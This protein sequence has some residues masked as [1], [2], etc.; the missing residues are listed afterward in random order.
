MTRRRYNGPGQ[1]SA[2]NPNAVVNSDTWVGKALKVSAEVASGAWDGPITRSGVRT[3]DGQT[4]YTGMRVLLTQQA[5]YGNYAAHAQNG[6]WVANDDGPWSRPEDYDESKDVARAMVVAVSGGDLEHDTLY[7][8]KGNTSITPGVSVTSWRKISSDTTRRFVVSNDPLIPGHYD[9][10]DDALF[11]ISWSFG[12]SYGG[13]IVLVGEHEW[14][15]T[16]YSGITIEGWVDEPYGGTGASIEGTITLQTGTKLKSLTIRGKIV[17]TAGWH[18]Y[19]LEKLYVD[20]SWASVAGPCFKT[21]TTE[22]TQ[23]AI[24]DC[25]FV[26]WDANPTIEL[27]ETTYGFIENCRVYAFGAGDSLTQLAQSY[28]GTTLQVRGCTMDRNRVTV[29][30]VQFSNCALG[31]IVANSTFINLIACTYGD[32]SGPGAIGVLGSSGSGL[33]SSAV[34]VEG[35]G[36]EIPTT[37]I[38]AS[39]AITYTGWTLNTYTWAS[40]LGGGAAFTRTL[41]LMNTVPRR[42]VRFINRDLTGGTLTVLPNA[43]DTFCYGGSTANTSIALLPGDWA[44]FVPS[45]TAN[46]WNVRVGRDALAPIAGTGLTKTG[47]TLAADFGTGAGKVTQ[48]NDSR[49]SDARTP[50]TAGTNGGVMAYA[51][52][53]WATTGAGTTGQ[54]LLSN[55]SGAAAFGALTAVGA[56]GLTTT[57]YGASIIGDVES[58]A[59]NVTISAAATQHDVNTAAARTLTLPSSESLNKV[60]VIQD[61]TGGAATFNITV[62]APA[63]ETIN[64]AASVTISTAWAGRSFR[65]VGASSWAYAQ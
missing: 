49:L 34:G 18:F 31:D 27:A 9:N 6:L 33:K 48:A 32:V 10:L 2:Y 26:Q 41:P 3:V 28:G 46:V 12:G 55:G 53:A 17:T 29:R 61:V 4:T 13:T 57:Q 11:D 44:E 23:V 45:T 7:I 21:V 24:R 52:G 15:G 20:S 40:G 1:P 63:G 59:S 54:P 65:K 60:H 19:E 22:R 50:S 5:G 58:I 39:A 43:A 51:G 8:L 25:E 62:N 36:A 14:T 16:V 47:N 42:V 64:G 37:S 56:T 38:A 30:L 35:F